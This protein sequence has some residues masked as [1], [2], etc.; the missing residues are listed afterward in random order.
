[1]PLMSILLHGAV[2]MAMVSPV[3]SAQ[4]A[5]VIVPVADLWNDVAVS[6]SPL[7]ND[8][9]ET[10]LL[11]GER[12]KVLETKGPWSRIEAVQQ[13][14]YSHNNRWEGYPGWVRSEALDTAVVSSPSYV[15]TSDWTQLWDRR[16]NPTKEMFFG[17]LPIGAQI[18]PTGI[19]Q[20][21]IET[22]QMG[23]SGFVDQERLLSLDRPRS[24]TIRTDILSTASKFLGTPYLWGGLS[25]K[26]PTERPLALSTGTVQAIGIDCSGLVHIAHR[27]HGVSVPRDSHEQW[28]KAKRIDARDLKPGDLIFAAKADKPEKIVHVVFYVGKQEILEAP[29]TGMVVRRVSFKEKFG[30]PLS[31]LRSGDRAQDRI[32]YFGRLLS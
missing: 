26:L 29:Q 1:M 16:G 11:F 8:H 12:V 15:S 19:D 6:T 22:K 20:N 9:R 14:E 18:S 5:V 4:D 28:M 32:L 30:K 10:Q 7:T 21:W 2:L 25:Q 3:M 27:V 17:A 13:E 31:G 24:S 23:R